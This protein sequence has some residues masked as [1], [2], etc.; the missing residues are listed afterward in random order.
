VAINQT[1]QLKT[2]GLYKIVRHPGYLG[3]IMITAGL[4]IGMNSLLS[5]IVVTIPIFL[6]IMYRIYVEEKVLIKEFGDRYMEYSQSTKK[7]LPYFF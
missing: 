4:S 2:D 5:F 6:A 7:L 1:H 3:L